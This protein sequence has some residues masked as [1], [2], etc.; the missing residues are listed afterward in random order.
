MRVLK[1][2]HVYR[3]RTLNLRVDT[4]ELDSGRVTLRE[5][6]EYAMAVTLVPVTPQGEI[7]FVRQYRH[8]VGQTLL[9]LPAGKVEEGESPEAAAHREL[10]EETGYQAGKLERLLEFYVAP[11]YSQERMVIFLAQDLTPGEAHPDF[12]EVIEVV[13]FP[14][15]EV[16]RRLREG[17]FRD[18]K[19]IAGLFSYLFRKGGFP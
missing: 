3:G 10:M 7:V 1:S 8:S 15:E 4:V 11:G 5:V 9:E 13:R 16:I 2:E 19:T 12:D 18:G 14:E 17:W 6:V